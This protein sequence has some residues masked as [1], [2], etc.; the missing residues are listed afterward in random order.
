MVDSHSAHSDAERPEERQDAHRQTIVPLFSAHREQSLPPTALFKEATQQHVDEHVSDADGGS[1]STLSSTSSTLNDIFAQVQQDKTALNLGK[2]HTVKVRHGAKSLPEPSV[3]ASASTPHR[4]PLSLLAV[5]SAVC[6]ICAAVFACIPL[7][8][9]IAVLF[10]LLAVLFGISSINA[11]GKSGNARGRLFAVFA[12]VVGLLASAPAMYMSYTVSKAL[13]GAPEYP[14]YAREH[15]SNMSSSKN[16]QSLVDEGDTDITD[17]GDVALRKLSNKKDNNSQTGDKDSTPNPEFVKIVDEY[18]Q[19]F[20]GYIDFLNAH[21]K[22]SDKK[23]AVYQNYTKKASR[24]LVE[25]HQLQDNKVLSQADL[26]YYLDTY[27]RIAQK[28]SLFN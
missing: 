25:F 21:Q 10:A 11:T 17:L 5:S 18:E 22:A 4:K 24:K 9:Y 15:S 13:Y 1:A 27:T 8:C 14:R 2:R 12:I 6:A 3:P 28:L 20:N 26:N 19:F 23:S 16:N 7:A